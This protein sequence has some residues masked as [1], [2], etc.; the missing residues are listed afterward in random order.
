LAD[1]DEKILQQS[2]E[3]AE[4]KGFSL[5][6]NE[7]V[8]KAVISGLARNQAEKGKP[9]CPC[10]ANTG[11]EK[12]D[13]KNVCPCAFHLD[14]IKQDGHCKCLLFFGEKD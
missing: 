7:R 13:A 9:F 2:K 11:N 8:L 12:E 6:N 14:E 4:S 3:Y 10:R 1:L 5:N